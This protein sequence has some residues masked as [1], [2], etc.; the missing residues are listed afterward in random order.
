MKILVFFICALGLALS[1]LADDEIKEEFRG[2]VSTIQSNLAICMIENNVSEEEILT[3]VDKESGNE[4]RRRKLGCTYACVLKRENLME[5][6][7]IKEREVHAKINTNYGPSLIMPEVH[8]VARNCVKEVRNITEECEKGFSLLSCLI[9]EEDKSE[10]QEEHK[11]SK[12]RLSNLADGK[13][14]G[15]FKSTL[16]S[17]HSNLAICM[18]ENS[19]SEDD[20]YTEEEIRADV[21]KESGNEERTRKLGCTI[22]CFLKKEHLIEGSN[23]KQRLVRA[24]INEEYGP[25]VIMP[26]LHEVARECI[27]EVRNITEECEKSFSL[28]NCLQKNL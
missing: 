12:T 11:K 4:E 1:N 21:H 9:K 22:A 18:I 10:E 27:K 15:Q 6:S 5:D 14:K 2:A 16:S 17:I 13:I 7:N 24:K 26:A 20:W 23:I 25:S 8:E 3:G 28:I 19:V